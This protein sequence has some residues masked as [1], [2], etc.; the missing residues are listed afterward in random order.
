MFIKLFNLNYPVWE[1][2]E[3]SWNRFENINQ[4]S[5]ELTASCQ[6][7]PDRDGSLNDCW[8]N[9]TLFWSS[10]S[11]ALDNASPFFE[12]LYHICFRKFSD[13]IQNPLLM[14]LILLIEDELLSFSYAFKAWLETD[15]LRKAYNEITA[16]YWENKTFKKHYDTKLYLYLMF[17]VVKLVM[18]KNLK[19]DEWIRL[20]PRSNELYPFRSYEV[21]Q[22]V[23][24]YEEGV[25]FL[26]PAADSWY[27]EWSDQS[28][29]ID[30]INELY[31]V[32]YSNDIKGL[33]SLIFA[34]SHRQDIV[35]CSWYLYKTKEYSSTLL[36]QLWGAARFPKS[37]QAL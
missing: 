9:I 1:S 18:L 7:A 33:Y 24:V 17:R 12:A 6:A 25:R 31:G 19:H 3:E 36:Q 37:L 22:N 14:R 5:V 32:D 34:A 16:P 28:V 10:H 20:F 27:E 15:A 26:I 4:L 23:D 8:K 35:T 29:M 11:T 2:K 30:Q 21:Y 13:K